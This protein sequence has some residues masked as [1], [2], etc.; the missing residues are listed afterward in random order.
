MRDAVRTAIGKIMDPS[1][2][3]QYNINGNKRS[4]R[5]TKNAF[6]GLYNIVAALISIDTLYQRELVF[7][8][9]KQSGG[10]DVGRR[11]LVMQRI[12]ITLAGAGDLKGMHRDDTRQQK[13]GA[14]RQSPSA[15]STPAASTSA[16]SKSPARTSG[17]KK[18]AASKSGNKKSQSVARKNSESSTDE[19]EEEAAADSERSH[20]PTP[21]Q[22][23]DG[24]DD[25]ESQSQSLLK[26]K[27]KGSRV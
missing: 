23:R 5:T 10:T 11:N 9:D 7:P 17:G 24:S 13:A 14:T 26:Q 15:A 20:S 2:R 27:S 18:L 3:C 19:E 6:R 16:G 8:V 12:R 1:L 22:S 21:S 4:G 25:E